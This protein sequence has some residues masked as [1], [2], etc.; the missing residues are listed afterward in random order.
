MRLIFLGTPR[1]AASILEHLVKVTKH[2]ILAV[3][4]KPDAP[5]GRGQHLVVTPVKETAQKLLPDVPVFQPNKVSDAE[6][7]AYLRGFQ[8]DACVVVAYGEIL[9]PPFLEIPRLGTY[10]IHASLLPS[11]RGAAPIQ[12]ALMDGCSHSGITIFRIDRALD[13]GDLVWQG[14]CAISP[15]MTAGELTEELLELA[16]RG[17]VESLDRIE[18]GTVTFR[19][20]PHEEATFA[21]KIVPKDLILDPAQD[22]LHIHDRIR[23]LSPQPGAYFFVQYRDQK[24]RLKVFRSHVDGSYTAP[25]PR[26][27]V[28]PQGFLGLSTPSGTLVLEIVQF[29]GRSSMPSNQFLRGVPLEELFFLPLS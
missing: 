9:K 12:R 13:S 11:Y 8:P 14:R 4:S 26:W 25:N 3:V 20:Q 19:H 22:I 16:K 2:D 6:S 21:P 5:T 7:V 27:C 24:K 17:I 18:Q 1:F 10:N 15:N 23:A 29:E 28:V